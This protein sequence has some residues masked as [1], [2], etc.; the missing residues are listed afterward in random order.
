MAKERLEGKISFINHEKHYAVIEYMQATKKKTVNGAIDE[1]TQE[2]A[3][4][5]KFMRR[6][7][8]YA[9]GDV[10]SFTIRTSPRGDKMIATDIQFRYNN[11]LETL[12]H[13]AELTNKFK[14]YIKEADGKFFIKEIDTYVFFPLKISPWQIPPSED[15]M[16]EA[17]FFSLNN[18][19]NKEKVTASLFSSNYIPEFHQAVKAYK[20]KQPIKA[21]IWN[22]TAHGIYIDLFGENLRAKIPLGKKYGNETLGES[23]KIGDTMDVLIT[24]IG[25]DRI[26]VKPVI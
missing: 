10:V 22:I 13:K 21:K 19:E 2:E 5:K 20:A 11:A 8:L 12:V 4:Q 25:D 14:G 16:E 24:H 1:K 26:I 6:H 9:I 18:I 23:M 3:I 17:V 7:H 15:E